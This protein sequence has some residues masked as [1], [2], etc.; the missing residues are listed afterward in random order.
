VSSESGLLLSKKRVEDAWVAAVASHFV[1]RRD[2]EIQR[3]I[4]VRLRREMKLIW[5]FQSSH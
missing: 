5:V 2:D 3:D 4:P 1:H